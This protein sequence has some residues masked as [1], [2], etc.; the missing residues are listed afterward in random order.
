VREDIDFALPI[1]RKI[2]DLD[3]GQSLAVK[4]REVI[5]VEAI[6]GTA[7][8]IERCGQYCKKGGW[9]LVKIAKSDQDMR[10]DVPCVGTDTIKSLA[11]NKA[12]ALA[13]Q[14]GKTI[15]IDKEQTIK[16][17]DKMKISIIG[18]EI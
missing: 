6:E 2:A 12:R 9:T 11:E 5:A 16:L 13:L 4:E 7:K 17:A 18:L 3:I 15:I 1:A 10:F 8:L 14:A